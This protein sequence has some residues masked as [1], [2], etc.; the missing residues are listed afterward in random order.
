MATLDSFLAQGIAAARAGNN[1]TA[2]Q[3]L[4]RAVR[5]NPDSE[6]AWL[7]LGAVLRT[8][9]GRTF[10]LRKVLALNPANQTAQQGLEVLEKRQRAPAI[11]AQ[12]PAVPVPRPAQVRQP[13][14]RAG[15]FQRQRFWQV[16]VACLGIIAVALVGVLAYANLGGSRAAGEDLQAAILPIP[17]PAPRQ[18][19]RPTFTPTPTDT[20]PPTHT[21]TPTPTPTP[22][23]TSTPTDTLT[24]TPTPTATRQR[25]VRPPPAAT[26]TAPAPSPSP[27]PTLPP[28]SLDPRLVS[29][30]VR[31][32][33]AFV[34]PGQVYWRLIE[35]QWANERE[36]GGKHSIFIEVSEVHGNRAVGQSVI[37]QWAD[38]SIVL[39][40][41]DPPPPDWPVDFPMYS[42]LGSY[43]VS[44]E[45]APSDRIVGLGLGTAEDPHMKVHTSF[46]LTFH[47]V[48]R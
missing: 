42:T 20:P 18:T 13:S 32:E 29:L 9:Q 12:S 7:W 47:R 41:E 22:L 26:P 5:Q 48:Y 37:V 1:D 33:P 34:A 3:L 24:P 15:L 23:P 16:V 10:C 17:S 19:L 44:L 40:V 38:G 6:A 28:R 14:T 21:P 31:I 4:T 2:R 35:A 45:G 8:P 27:R 30:G 46:Y 39:P 43:A 25:V 11:V 36:A